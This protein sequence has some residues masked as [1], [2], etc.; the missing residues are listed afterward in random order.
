M[1]GCKDRY[2]IAL[3]TQFQHA[4]GRHAI[5]KSHCIVGLFWRGGG[6]Q[7]RLTCM[8][9]CMQDSIVTTEIHPHNRYW[10][11]SWECARQTRF[12]TSQRRVFICPLPHNWLPSLSSSSWM[13]APPVCCRR[14]HH[15]FLMIMA[16]ST[17]CRKDHATTTTYPW[18]SLW[19][20]LSSSQRPRL[21]NLC[22]AFCIL[23]KHIYGGWLIAIQFATSVLLPI[24]HVLVVV[25]QSK[26]TQ[27]IYW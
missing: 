10:F 23:N 24:G 16:G 27:L 13:T 4:H 22:Q 2:Y 19:G 5:R 8:P 3:G 11:R 18:L 17:E 7:R 15:C 25:Y 6:F 12:E 20:N 14:M 1:L 21:M 26:E 9:L